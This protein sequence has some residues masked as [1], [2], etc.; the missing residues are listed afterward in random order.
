MTEQWTVNS[1]ASLDN[2][3][4]HIRKVYAERKYVTVTW[5]T[6]Q[7]RSEIQNNALHL[8]CRNLA[9]ELN[10]RGLDMKKVLK[11][12]VEIPWTEYSAKEHLWKP[13]Q[14]SLT[15]HISTTKPKRDEY[16]LIYE[17]LNRHLG[18][19]LGVHVEWPQR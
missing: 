8:Y 12:E 3:I 4:K 11:P 17:T 10:E 1:D 2:F 15:G 18:D 14:E 5:K 7:Q 19:K 13:I 9:N 16:P 6:G